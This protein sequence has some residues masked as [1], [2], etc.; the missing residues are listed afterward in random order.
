MTV[1][2]DDLQ[3]YWKSKLATYLHDSIDNAFRRKRPEK[4][5]VKLLEFLGVQSQNEDFCNKSDSIVSD[6]ERGYVLS[7]SADA[8]K[9]G[10]IDFTFYPIITYPT[11]KPGS[12]DSRE[13]LE[14]MLVQSL[15]QRQILFLSHKY[16]DKLHNDKKYPR[17]FNDFLKTHKLRKGNKRLHSGGAQ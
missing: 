9:N 11:T 14:T 6:F 15:F 17:N 13:N 3:I 4:K 16:N 7:Y 5:A 10:A 8:D 12:G 2:Y 1:L